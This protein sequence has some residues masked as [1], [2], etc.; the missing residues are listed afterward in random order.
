MKKILGPALVLLVCLLAAGCVVRSL[1]P[2]LSS[3]S[4]VKDPA[5]VGAWHD[6][7]EKC[8][9]FFSEADDSDYD[10]NVLM[11]NNGTDVSRF[12]ASLHKLDE[13]LLLTVGPGD[14]DNLN[15]IVMLPGYLLLK[16]ETAGDSLQL[17]DINLDTFRERAEKAQVTLVPD[18][19][20]NDGYTL[21]GDTEAIE[22]FV[23]AQLA[24]P[25]FF[26]A[27]PLYSFRKLP[28]AAP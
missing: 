25:E 12:T 11:V 14:P 2:W 10:Y 19:S 17:Y 23:R 16:A 8:T 26:D 9:A 7:K 20:K 3:E 28:A 6:A 13:H 24:D 15:G 21:G 5:L 18:G 27:D 22:A 4:R 1:Q